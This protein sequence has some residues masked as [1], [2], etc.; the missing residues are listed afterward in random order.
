MTSIN[1]LPGG[2]GGDFA[3]RGEGD[4]MDKPCKIKAMLIVEGEICEKKLE[5][6]RRI[7]RSNLKNYEIIGCSVEDSN[8]D[9]P[10]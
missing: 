10:Q 2:G 5:D 4:K 9:R 8:G 1:L 7:F 6:L 3:A